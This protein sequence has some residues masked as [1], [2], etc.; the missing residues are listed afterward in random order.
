VKFK[1]KQT[2]KI[3]YKILLLCIIVMV[4]SIILQES[5][6]KYSDVITFTGGI[7]GFILGWNLVETD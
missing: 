1:K 2:M 7:I 6:P 4:I 3:N 5:F